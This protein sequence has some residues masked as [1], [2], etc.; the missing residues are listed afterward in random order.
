MS[1][2]KHTY[3][4]E[5]IRVLRFTAQDG[6]FYI[7]NFCSIADGVTILLGGNH[8]MDWVTTYP[9]T[10]KNPPIADWTKADPNRPSAYT[11]GDIVVG[12]DVWIGFNATILS[13]VKIGDGAV[14]GA[15][16]VVTRDVPPYSIVA[17]NPATVRKYRFRPD[18][19]EA[20]LKIKW[21]YWD[22]DTINN[23]MDLICSTNI[24]DFIRASQPP[25][26]SMTITYGTNEARS[27][28]THMLGP[29]GRLDL[30]ANYSAVIG[31]PAY[32]MPKTLRI[33]HPSLPAPITVPEN[34]PISIFANPTPLTDIHVCVST[35]AD[36]DDMMSAWQMA[37][38]NP[39][40]A[41]VYRHPSPSPEY[42]E[43]ARRV[44]ELLPLVDVLLLV[45]KK[46][47]SLAFRAIRSSYLSSLPDPST[48]IDEVSWLGLPN[49][50]WLY[51]EL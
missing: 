1:I 28:V 50:R 32:G 15:C 6:L 33:E 29:N 18:Q 51:L 17:G 5:K 49:Q 39:N 21:W 41:I 44:L 9:F 24:D 14:V 2:G 16:S 45:L 4:C 8:R 3:G 26:H 10:Y 40:S 7:G 20:L 46:D 13:G 38:S 36:K 22:D 35:G 34:T 27:N 11:K 43:Y 47:I 30:S 48:N 12:N 37:N 31:D 23:N 42:L 25:S 19:I